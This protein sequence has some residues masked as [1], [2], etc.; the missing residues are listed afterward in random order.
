MSQATIVTNSSKPT[1]YAI[2]VPNTVTFASPMAVVANAT[3]PFETLTDIALVGVDSSGVPVTWERKNSLPSN[4]VN[5]MVALDD[6]VT[7]VDVYCNARGTDITRWGLIGSFPVTHDWSCVTVSSNGGQ[8]TSDRTSV[9][10]S[11]GGG[12]KTITFNTDTDLSVDQL[13]GPTVTI[14]GS[15]RSLTLAGATT[16]T[17]TACDS[18]ISNSLTIDVYDSDANVVTVSGPTSS[19]ANPHVLSAVSGNVVVQNLQTS[20]KVEVEWTGGPVAA[21]VD[22]HTGV[23]V[24][25]KTIPTPA[26]DSSDTWYL[27]WHNVP[28]PDPKVIIKRTADT[29]TY[30]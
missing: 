29:L 2:A 22:K 21:T 14:T 27:H 15:P 20:V 9:Y 26:N 17:V 11:T 24:P 25:S 16:L 23:V 3:D 12:A 19:D 8:L 1:G 6:T 7:Q 13:G 10:L 28:D 4:G 5:I 30:E 18:A